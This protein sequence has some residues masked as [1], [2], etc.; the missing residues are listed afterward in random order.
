M[1]PLTGIKVI[2]M[3]AIGPVPF[4][5]MMLSDMG[6]EVIRI[7]RL[8][9]KGSG[10]SAN[11]LY[12]GRKSVAF[13][14][15][16]SIALDSTLRLSDQADVILE[17]F[18]PGVMERL[19]LGPEVCLERNPKLI[20]GRMTGWG[21]SGPLSHAA[22]HDINYISIAGALGS[23]GYADRPPAPPL[24]LIGDFGG[25]AM[26]LLAGILAAIVERN[27][28]GKGQVVDAAMTDGTASLLSPF[29]G[30]MAMGMWSTERYSNRL[31]GGAFYYGSYECSDGKYISLG[32]LEPQF[33]ALLLEKCGITDETFKEQS[34][35]EAW[36]IKR[37][38]M[39]ALFKTK[40]QQEWCGILEGTDVCFA[41]VL[42]LKEAPD[43]PHNKTRQTFVKVQG[44]TQPAPAPR[45]SRTQGKIQS[46][47]A[48]TGENT[49][50]VLSDWGFSDSE[51]SNLKMNNMI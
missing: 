7:D 33:Y 48:L 18:R 51:I 2:E 23:M 16:N 5:A 20:Y 17:G 14:L 47:A 32:S 40:T 3:A 6:A 13:D 10:S 42:N 27:S 11:V 28:S 49:E 4:C 30:L 19:G 41:P 39:E 46:P 12:R 50:E 26:Y 36:P 21:Q 44:V 22:G 24:N 29:Y 37:E 43:H 35:Q 25:G 31:D 8:S 34:D 9:Q 45:F 1:G 38:K 15:K